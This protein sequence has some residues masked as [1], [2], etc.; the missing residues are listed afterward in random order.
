MG[1]WASRRISRMNHETVLVVEDGVTS[2][3]NRC[4]ISEIDVG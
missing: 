3:R 1:V 4:R 2:R